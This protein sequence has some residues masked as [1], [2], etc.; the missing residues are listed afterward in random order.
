MFLIL[1]GISYMIDDAGLIENID[2]KA[3]AKLADSDF[4][5]IYCLIVNRK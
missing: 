5:R 3:E 2:L 1:H 4:R